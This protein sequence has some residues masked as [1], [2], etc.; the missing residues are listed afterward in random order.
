M[1]SKED[2]LFTF[3]LKN[4]SFIR[5]DAGYE[6]PKKHVKDIFDNKEL[7]TSQNEKHFAVYLKGIEVLILKT[8]EINNC[9]WG[10]T[11]D[12]WIF[13]YRSDD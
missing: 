9:I 6:N 8:R 11:V 2:I 13:L 5:F 12:G 4:D 1:Q 7:L 10:E 3:K